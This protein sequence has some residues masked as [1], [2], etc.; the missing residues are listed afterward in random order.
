[1]KALH[2]FKIGK[3][4]TSGFFP[5]IASSINNM[6]QSVRS[7]AQKIEKIWF[8]QKNKENNKI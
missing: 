7:P 2:F 8:S 4:N 1:M 5:V 6:N 3:R